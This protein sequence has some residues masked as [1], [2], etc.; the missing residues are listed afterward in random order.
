LKRKK[1]QFS[2]SDAKKLAGNNITVW[3][4]KIEEVPLPIIY[5]FDDKRRKREVEVVVG[6]FPG[7]GVHYHVDIREENDGVLDRSINLPYRTNP[8]WR[9]CWND[10]KAKGK[11]FWEKFDNERDVANYIKKI[12][13]K[14]FSS[15]THKLRVRSLE[16]IKRLK[17]IGLNAK[18]SFY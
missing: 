14:E 9:E 3:G 6:V 1:A 8:V 18:H 7:I 4:G 17:K 13:K 15:K 10:E 5:F 2:I 12:W 11:Q 16:I